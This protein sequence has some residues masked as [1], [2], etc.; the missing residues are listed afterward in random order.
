M[1]ITAITSN[2][3]QSCDDLGQIDLS[4][5]KLEDAAPELLNVSEMNFDQ[6]V[7]LQPSAIT[8]FGVLRKEIHRRYD[9]YKR[10]YDRWTKKMYATAKVAVTSGTQDSYK[11]TVAD[12]EARF[13][14]D[15]EK[16]I[17]K[18]EKQLDKLRDEADTLD[19][20]YEGWRQKSFTIREWAGIENDER[21]QGGGSI[22]DE[23]ATFGGGNGN[24]QRANRG[25]GNVKE[26]RP[27]SIKRVRE[28]MRKRK[29]DAEKKRLATRAK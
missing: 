27:D 25:G 7:A 2:I 19:A 24:G 17:E 16:E 29:E 12:I 9:A 11:P 10:S 20:W 22:V 26:L 8:F 23:N 3:K 6:H 15:N 21:Y 14:V 13:I 28:M 5:I 4:G 18:R 1:D